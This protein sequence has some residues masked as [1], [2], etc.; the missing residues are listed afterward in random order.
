MKSV[1]CFGEVLI[2]FLNT[3]NNTKHTDQYN[4]YRQYPGGAPA[5]TAVAIAKLG[6]LSSFAGQVGLDPFGKFLKKSL[7][8]YHVDTKYLLS[9]PSAKTALAFVTL[10]EVGERSFTFYR[11]QTA[12][13]LCSP[14]HVKSEW[15]KSAGCFHF[16]SNTLTTDFITKTTQKALLMAS[17]NNVLISF[18]VNLRPDLWSKSTILTDRVN[19]FVDQADVVKF[20]KEEIKYLSEN[21]TKTYIN[22]RLENG[23]SLIIVT[24]GPNDI[25]FYNQR[26]TG[27]I[28]PPKVIAIDTTAGGDAFCG[29]FLFGLSQ[30]EAPKDAMK[31][32]EK[33]IKLIEFASFC[34][35]H[36]VTKQGAF[37]ALPLWDDVKEY[38]PH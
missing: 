29:A 23:V 18:D 1:I 11:E 9:H 26:E 13:V 31:Q 10:D 25:H 12:D 4:Q 20:S 3:A 17:E 5:N 36:T 22:Q 6:G 28:I 37:P 19:N 24:D 14:S 35:A 7:N 21:K 33:F 27:V 34:G 2:D 8:Q 16:C 30:F 32:P 15:F 38:Y